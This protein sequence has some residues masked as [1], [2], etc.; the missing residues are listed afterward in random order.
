MRSIGRA[1]GF[2]SRTGSGTSAQTSGC[3]CRIS[4]TRSTV[5]ASALSPRSASPCSTSRCGSASSATRWQVAHPPQ[6]SSLRRSQFA[7]CANMRARVN[8]P[9]PRGPVKSSEWGTRP[10]R[11]APRS[12]ATTRSL[13]RKSE[14][15]MVS[16]SS[17][18]AQRIARRRRSAM[19]EP[20]Q[21]PRGRSP[22]QAEPSRLFSRSTR[23]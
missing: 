13:Q 10:L 6:K 23:R 20:P 4:G 21:A 1:T 8:L 18:S 14:K 12:A 16:S 3:G 7:A 2:F 11:R 9:T 22:P 19:A 17:P 5:A 15:P